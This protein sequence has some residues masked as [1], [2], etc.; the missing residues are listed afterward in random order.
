L[1]TVIEARR[2]AFRE[3]EFGRKQQFLRAALAAADRPLCLVLG[4]SRASM[5]LRPSSL[6]PLS[7][8][9]GR[10]AAVF[11]FA[12]AGAGAA[13]Q[14]LTLRRLIADA[15]RPRWVVVEIPQLSLTEEAAATA[16]LPPEHQGWTDVR[17]L[18]PDEAERRRGY[19]EWARARA[20]PAFTYRF[21]L[22]RQVFPR[23]LPDHRKADEVW[24]GIDRDGWMPMKP[25]EDA[26]LRERMVRGQ[27]R[28]H[29]EKLGR[30]RLGAASA[31]AVRDLLAATAGAGI[32]TLLLTFPEG[33]SYRRLYAPGF[34][35]EC[36]A[37]LAAACR[38]AGAATAD[39]G[40]W[41]ADDGFLDGHHMLPHAADAFTR[42]FGEEVLGPFLATH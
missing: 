35:E 10:P 9:D 22:L 12:L 39:V 19:F 20:V 41:V 3:P 16:D 32:P 42:R 2:P 25:P 18:Y 17:V 8:P 14:H 24:D 36:G 38:E 11:N 37:F 21:T 6:P 1:V 30:G 40:D 5:G 23:W 28:S 29:G 7:A 26:G 13:R 27:Y 15:V 34:R 33:P 4:S 31:A